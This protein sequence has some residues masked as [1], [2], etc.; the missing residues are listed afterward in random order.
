MNI[1]LDT[2][3]LGFKISKEPQCGTTG[4]SLIPVGNT[5]LVFAATSRRAVSPRELVSSRG[6]YLYVDKGAEK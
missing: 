4:D 3:S 6:A 1:H 2:E 5:I